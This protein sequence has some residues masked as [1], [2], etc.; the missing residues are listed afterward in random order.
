MYLVLSS[1]DQARNL[2]RTIK[3][4]FTSHISNVKMI[5]KNVFG[6]QSLRSSSYLKRIIK[7]YFT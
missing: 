7:L 1:Y 4:F 6:I 3:L 5:N 2:Q